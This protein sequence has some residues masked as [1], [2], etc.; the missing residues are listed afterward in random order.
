MDLIVCDEVTTQLGIS[1]ESHLVDWDTGIADLANNNYDFVHYV[2]HLSAGSLYARYYRDFC[3]PVGAFSHVGD[4]RNPE[5]TS[6]IE[7]LDTAATA[8][9]QPIANQIQTIIG[10]N[11][12]NIPLGSHPEWYIYNTKYWTG[13]PNGDHPFLLDGPYEG[14]TSIAQVQKILL[15]LE[16][17][18]VTPTP[19]GWPVEYTYA[20][21]AIVVI[22]ILIIL[23]YALMRRRK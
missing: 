4:Y 17:A 11:M 8:D 21:V 19:T 22:V 9:Q 23:G 6:L 16:P 5:L 1:L 12:P 20:A 18:G 7:S 15:M 13:W 3:G 14:P 2:M 10:E